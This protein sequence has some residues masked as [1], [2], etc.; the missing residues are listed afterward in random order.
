M[1][2]LEFRAIKLSKSCFNSYIIFN[3][4][5]MRNIKIVLL[6]IGMISFIACSSNDDD[7]TKN[8]NCY[9]CAANLV[10][11][12]PVAYCDNADGTADVTTLGIT[13]TVDLQGVPFEDFMTTV[14]A[15]TSCSK[16]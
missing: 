1:T 10:I 8:A 13:E 6:S 5:N 4:I 9:D 11:P 16:N 15:V 14:K 2:I 12:L 3:P 7:L